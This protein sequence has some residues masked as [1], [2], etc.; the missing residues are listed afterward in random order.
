M[1]YLTIYLLFFSGCTSSQNNAEKSQNP[2]QSPEVQL[3]RNELWVRAI[4][5][6]KDSLSNSYLDNSIKV[7]PSG[8]ILS[9]K[10]QILES[11]KSQ[12]R[13]SK[14]EVIKTVQAD[15]GDQFDY[16]IGVFTDSTGQTY[17]HLL[18]WD[19]RAKKRLLEFIAPSEPQKADTSYISTRRA[20]WIRYCNQHNVDL[21]VNDLYM[22]DA[23]YYNHRPVINGREKI[24]ETYSYMRRDTYQLT[25]TPLIVEPVN[26]HMAFEI[27]QCSGSY[28]GKYLLVW[29]R[30]DDGWKIFLDSNI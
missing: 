9:G 17:K 15:Q 20:E 4:N 24:T 2:G 8:E 1:R 18:I 27:G 7:L 22:I 25:L 26:E 23:I 12:S 29:K 10:T 16:E 21:L 14:V 11:Y 19:K 6:H 30:G 28:N 5:E 13:V 3:T